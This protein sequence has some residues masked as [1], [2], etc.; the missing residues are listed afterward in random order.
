MIIRPDRMVSVSLVTEA[1]KSRNLADTGQRPGRSP[2]KSAA[3]VIAGDAAHYYVPLLNVSLSSCNV[4]HND[5]DRRRTTT[6]AAVPPLFRIINDL[7]R[8][9]KDSPNLPSNL[10][11]IENSDWHRR[12]R[13][14]NRS[15]P[16]LAPFRP[17]L[18]TCPVSVS[19]APF[20]CFLRSFGFELRPIRGRNYESIE[21]DK[22][23]R[24]I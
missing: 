2:S 10:P 19:E 11:P 13:G 16:L 12:F 24:G 9:P 21:N 6:A 18:D 7:A 22:Q 14:I 8:T 23:S 3:L 4:G 5:R 20:C 17:C 1:T 15:R